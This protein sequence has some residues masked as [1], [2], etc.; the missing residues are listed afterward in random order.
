MKDLL[1][2]WQARIKSHRASF[3]E[4]A[5][6]LAE[7]DTSLRQATS[8]LRQLEQEVEELENESGE[9]EASLDS[10]LSTQEALMKKLDNVSKQY[11]SMPPLPGGE[12][13]YV[14]KAV[15]ARRDAYDAAMELESILGGLDQSLK[16]VEVNMREA[17]TNSQSPVREWL[18]AAKKTP[19]FPN[20][21][22]LSLSPL[23]LCSLPKCECFF[24]RSSR[25]FTICY[26]AVTSSGRRRRGCFRD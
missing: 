7:W 2:D 24:L 13:T 25:R 5:T 18:C 19:A 22:D 23:L 4:N 12:S 11:D 21:P 8:E 15:A 1:Q 10:M 6:K 3:I 20:F 14:G 26:R 17:E 9:V 16:L